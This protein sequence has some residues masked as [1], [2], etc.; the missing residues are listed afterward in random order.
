MGIPIEAAKK[1]ATEYGYEQV[2]IVARKVGCNEEG[3]HEHVTTYGVDESHCE[4]AARM[5]NFFKYKLMGWSAD[6]E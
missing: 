3:A 5:G 1:I 6:D 2:V 4:V